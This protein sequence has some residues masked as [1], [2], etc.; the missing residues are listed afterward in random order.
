[1]MLFLNICLYSFFVYI[2]DIILTTRSYRQ[3][4]AQTIKTITYL[5][6]SKHFNVSLLDQR[7]RI[8]RNDKHIRLALLITTQ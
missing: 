3:Q 1:M 5:I 6:I 2:S 7:D 4:R 8:A